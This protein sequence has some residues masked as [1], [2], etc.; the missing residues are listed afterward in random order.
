MFK[1]TFHDA[2]SLP[3]DLEDLLSRVQAAGMST[4]SEG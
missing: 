4:A 2:P 3:V 1:N